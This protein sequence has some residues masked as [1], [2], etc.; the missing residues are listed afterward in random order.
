[1]LCKEAWKRDRKIKQFLAIFYGIYVNGSEKFRK[2]LLITKSNDHLRE[3]FSKVFV[4]LRFPR[5]IPVTVASAERSFSKTK[6][7]KT[8]LRTSM[9]PDRLTV[10]AVL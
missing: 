1:L 9:A 4:T 10:L 2:N 7:I 5:T 8:Y 6:L 3:I